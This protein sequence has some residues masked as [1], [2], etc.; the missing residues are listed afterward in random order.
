MGGFTYLV[1]FAES[2]RDAQP[3]R[4]GVRRDLARVLTRSLPGATIADANGR[5]VVDSAEHVEPVLANLPG[6]ASFSPCRRA[7]LARVADAAVE[8]AA[9]A[10]PRGG[11]FRVQVKRVGLSHL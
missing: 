2:G 4:Q 11:S 5:L 1:R 7:S 3:G 9:E 6:V 8:V 10:L